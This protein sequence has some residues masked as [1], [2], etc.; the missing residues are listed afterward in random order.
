MGAK[1]LRHSH[2]VQ[3]DVS[4]RGWSWTPGTASWVEPT[5]C[6]L[7]AFRHIPKELHPRDAG[8]RRRLAEL[9]LYDRMCPGGGW[10]SGNPL[11]YGTAGIP[12]IGPTVWALLALQHCRDRAE[13]LRS[14][15]WLDHAYSQIQGPESLAL[16]H[17]CLEFYDRPVPALE[18]FLAA[19]NSNNQFLGHTL[20]AAWATISL[21]G[22]PRWLWLET[23]NWKME[24]GKWKLEGPNSKIDPRSPKT[25][26]LRV[27][28]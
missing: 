19:L 16:A 13:N 21:G 23:G 9:M 7:L 22:R 1:L 6:A 10:N 3:Q 28:T 4:L 8:R 12:R 11:V 25:R 26:V 14:L 18:P 20:A 2:V 15:D 5:S 24:T 27:G 17:L